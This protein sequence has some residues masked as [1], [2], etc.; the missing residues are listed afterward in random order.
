MPWTA[1]D[2]DGFK[3]G[4]SRKQKK[5]WAS[6]ANGALASCMDGGGNEK[7]CAGRAVRIANAKF[8]SENPFNPV[9]NGELR[10]KLIKALGL[11]EEIKE[12]PMKKDD[13]EVEMGECEMEI[14]RPGTHNG[15]EFSED[16]LK[17][18]ADNYHALKDELR[19]KLKITHRENQKTIAGLASY[20]DIVDVFLKAVEDGSKRLFAKVANVPKQVMDWISNRRFPERS[21]ELYPEF[22]L[23]TKEN[24]KVRRNVL[25]AVALL[26]HEMPA[27]SGMAPIKLEECLECQGT[28]CFIESL[29]EGSKE[30]EEMLKSYELLNF[31][32]TGFN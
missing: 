20:G 30:I 24:D 11:K 9:V 2:V 32:A 15:D 17:E 4:L 25:K 31:G 12:I 21:I 13:K 10:D 3:K 28:L 8:E 23:G 22:K 18:I 16:D 26:G 1:S 19:P 14:F 5:K 6:I 27:V 29:D 7:E